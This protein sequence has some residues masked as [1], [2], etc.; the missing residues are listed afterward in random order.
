MITESIHRLG[1]FEA[2]AQCNKCVFVLLGEVR[3]AEEV[4][5]NETHVSRSLEVC[6]RHSDPRGEF[7]TNQNFK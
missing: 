2:C 1:L 7:E 5:F 4:G 3:Q 6:S